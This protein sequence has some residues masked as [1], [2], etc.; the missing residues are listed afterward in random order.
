M[1]FEN[2]KKLADEK[3]LTIQTIEKSCELGQGTISKWKESNNPKLDSLRRVANFLG[4]SIE[5]LIAS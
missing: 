1:I 4:V 5:Q 3:N 2:I